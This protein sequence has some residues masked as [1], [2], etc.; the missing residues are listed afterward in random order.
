MAGTTYYISVDGDSNTQNDT[1][2]TLTHSAVA[3]QATNNDDFSNA[4]II[5]AQAF[6][7]HF[8]NTGFTAEA[9]E[10]AGNGTQNTGWYKYIAPMDGVVEFSTDG[11][12]IDTVM[13][14]FTGPDLANLTLEVS[15]DDSGT[16][17]ASFA[18]VK[19][20]KDQ[21]L[22]I[23]LDGKAGAVG[24]INLESIIHNSSQDDF[25]DAINIGAAR[26]ATL[27]ENI[28]GTDFGNR[29]TSLEVGEDPVALFGQVADKTVWYKWAPN[30]NGIVTID[31][32]GSNFD[33]VLGAFTSATGQI[34]DLVAVDFIEDNRATNATDEVKF[35]VQSGTIYY[36]AVGGEGDETGE[37][38][39]NLELIEAVRNNHFVDAYDLGTLPEIALDGLNIAADNEADEPLISDLS[40]A[41]HSVWYEWKPAAT[42]AYKINITSTGAPFDPVVAVFDDVA[43]IDLLAAPIATDDDSG[44]GT[45]S[46]V[47]F[48]AVAGQTYKIMVSGKTA[49]ET[50]NFDLELVKVTDATEQAFFPIS[51]RNNVIDAQ[52]T[53][54]IIF[55]GLPAGSQLL[56]SDLETVRSA[57]AGGGDV[58]I[59]AD[60]AAN[61]FLQLP[62]ALENTTVNFTAFGRSTADGGSIDGAAINYS[63]VIGHYAAGAKLVADDISLIEN[64]GESGNFNITLLDT[65]GSEVID[66]IQVKNVPASYSFSTGTDNGGGVYTFSDLTEL[67]NLVITASDKDV[68]E[69]LL[70]EVTIRETANADTIVSSKIFDV[71][72]AQ[73]LIEVTAPA[74]IIVSEDVSENLSGVV[75]SYTNPLT[76]TLSVANG[77]LISNDASV[78]AGSGTS[79]LTMVGTGDVLSAAIASGQVTYQSNANFS[80]ADTLTIDAADGIAVPVNDISAITITPVA[81]APTLSVSDAAGGSGEDI[82][83]DIEASLTDASET[84]SIAISGVPD[85]AS[86]SAGIVNP[87]GTV[88][89][90]EAE[91][92]NLTI[93]ANGSSDFDLTV[94]V[95]SE[96]TNGD[97]ATVTETI[98]V[99]LPSPPAADNG[100]INEPADP[101]SEPDTA[102][103]GDGDTIDTDS[104]TDLSQDN[105]SII[106]GQNDT[107][108]RVD[109]PLDVVAPSEKEGNIEESVEQKPVEGNIIYGGRDNDVLIVKPNIKDMFA[110]PG[111]DKAIFDVTENIIADSPVHLLDGGEGFDTLEIRLTSDQIQQENIREA[112]IKIQEFIAKEKQLGE[113]TLFVEIL[114]LELQNWEDIKIIID[115]VEQAEEMLSLILDDEEILADSEEDDASFNDLIEGEQGVV[116]GEAFPGAVS[117]RGQMQAKERVITSK[118]LAF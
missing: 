56:A 7:T 18:R 63:L 43:T 77:V 9:G 85:G 12:A 88:I 91:L 44:T 86:L 22:W 3:S 73:E 67:N 72:V 81:D 38:K 13:D 28:L 108:I 75:I 92:E 65:D 96:E 27:T 60:H 118:Q 78:T 58:S 113:E 87:N 29:F 62:D 74:A 46:E 101:V 23:A 30:T 54:H 94:T 34:N 26:Y 32:T 114:Q 82:P 57:D 98:T 55:S 50:G 89:L 45:N 5:G 8:D 25:A 37:Y 64:T 68:D 16:G 71:Q 24:Q 41:N 99:D 76:L 14:I 47:I 116:M 21:E 115:G 51:I 107:L 93:N 42:G 66:L 53:N 20:T 110:G 6:T 15:D 109:I 31:T 40:T 106:D 48:T 36:L 84:L 61:S 2:I 80:G 17:T 10:T 95:T 69:S 100:S 117:L 112:L 97:V 11:S 49:Q 104:N 90:T 105:L 111:D 103:I 39:L 1:S 79:T 4:F 52:D 33:T 59:D 102:P 19:V 83:L 70:L 35:A